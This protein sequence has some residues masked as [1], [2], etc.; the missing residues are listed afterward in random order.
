MQIKR[1]I[2]D[3]IKEYI[4]SDKI[5]I[6]RWPRQVGKT[7]LMKQLQNTIKSEKTVF[8]NLDNLDLINKIKTPNDLISYLKFEYNYIEW[9][10]IYLFLD[11]FQ[12]IKQSWLFLKNIYDEYKNIKLICSWSSSLEITKN[13]EFLT[14]RKFIFDITSFN[15]SEY[16]QAKS[17]KNFNL[18]FDIEKD[19]KELELFYSTYKN[20][21]ERYFLEYLLIWWYPEVVLSSGKERQ[22]II[23]E[24]VDT[25]IKKDITQFLKIENILAFNNL[26]KLLSSQIWNLVNKTEI[27][28]IIWTSINTLNKYIDI[29]V[30]TYVFS[31][32]SPFYT[33]IRKEIVKMQK[34]FCRDLWM[35]NY[36][37]YW[38]L[39]EF[40]I[41]DIWVLVENFIYNELY[42]KDNYALNIYQTISRSEIDFIFS[43]AYNKIIPIEVK[44]R[45]KVN[46]PVVMKNFGENYN[47]KIDKKILFTKDL[48]KQEYNTYY[49]PSCLIWFVKL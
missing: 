5:L 4:F 10:K 28:W 31:F 12:N 39:E 24:I 25:Y 27:N 21:I 3:E 43:K 8:L 20:E 17:F 36:L 32:V 9:E 16:L 11:E 14:W 42:I 40:S 47:D 15:F 2:F 45:N 1:K 6:L 30:G 48:L 44:Y 49:I 13:T 41:S 23:K 18:Q 37:L 46:F 19:F 33:N 7:T 26:I 35:R 29:L 22:Y 34:V 38:K